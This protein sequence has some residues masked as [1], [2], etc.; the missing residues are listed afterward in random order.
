[1][2]RERFECLLY[3][4]GYRQPG[5][6]IAVTFDWP[7]GTNPTP[8][9]LDGGAWDAA[10]QTEFDAWWQRSGHTQGMVEVSDLCRPGVGHLSAPPLSSL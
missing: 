6:P 2:K 3:V 8:E 9:R 5:V 4:D 10:C 7:D 1:M